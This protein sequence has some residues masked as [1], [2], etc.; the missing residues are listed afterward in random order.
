MVDQLTRTRARKAVIRATQ[1]FLVAILQQG[2]VDSKSY[3]NACSYAVRILGGVLLGRD[4][5][6]D[7]IEALDDLK[8]LRNGMNSPMSEDAENA[9]AQTANSNL[10]SLTPE[11][12]GSIAELLSG[13][14]PIPTETGDVNFVHDAKRRGAG[15]IYTPYDVTEYMCAQTLPRLLEACETYEDVL[16][17]NIIDP[18]V[19]SGAFLAQAFRHITGYVAKQW[20]E[21][22]S[23]S[24]IEIPRNVLFG[25]DIDAFAGGLCKFVLWLEANGPSTSVGTGIRTADSLANGPV[26]PSNFGSRSSSR[27]PNQ[28]D[29]CIGNPPYVRIRPDEYAKFTLSDSRNLYGL[30][31]ELGLGL[32]T[33]SGTFSMIVPQSIMGSKETDSIRKL[34]L[35]QNGECTFQVFDSVPDF[36]FDQGKLDS[37]TNTNINQRTCIITVDFSRPHSVHTSPFIRWRRK[38]ERQILFQNLTTFKLEG[39]YLIRNQLPMIGSQPDRKLL[40]LMLTSPQVIGDTFGEGEKELFMTKAVRY[41]ITATPTDLKRKNSMVLPIKA[42]SYP[43]VHVLLNSNAFYWWWRVMGN[44]FQISRSDV[45]LFPLIQIDHDFAIEMSYRLLRAEKECRVFKKNAG[46]MIPNINFNYRQDLLLEI[47]AEVMKALGLTDSSPFLTSKS[48]SLRGDLSQLVGY[49]GFS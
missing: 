32:V 41:F 24:R 12:L 18:A 35:K 19:G 33:D 48:N 27:F 31:C 6:S 47:D 37:N 20:P 2:T 39:D 42:Q 49:G 10:N 25:L 13:H 46:K 7:E 15:R 21:K 1:S 29:L 45:E 3:V 43:V 34:L 14:K 26:L 38:E 17:L 40:D 44:G 9:L 23:D 16:G 8:I 5:T 28:F 11:D 36:L 4:I 30:F 22:Q